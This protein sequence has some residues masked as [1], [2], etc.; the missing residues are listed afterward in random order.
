MPNS[1]GL[2]GDLMSCYLG[3][4][5]HR[6]KDYG[7]LGLQGDELMLEEWQWPFNKLILSVAYIFLW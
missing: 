5:T 4:L 3:T 7:G 2:V 6:E 1:D